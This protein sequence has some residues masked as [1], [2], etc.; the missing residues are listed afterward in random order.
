MDIRR[1]TGAYENFQERNRISNLC[2]TIQS[3]SR[4]LNIY[5]LYLN[6]ENWSVINFETHSVLRA[7][8]FKLGK[9]NNSAAASWSCIFWTFPYERV[10]PSLW[11][12]FF[13]TPWTVAHQASLSITNFWSLPKLVSVES[14]MPSSHLILCCPLFLLPSVFPSIRIFSNES[15]LHISWL[16]YWSFSFT[17]SP[18]IEYSGLISFSMDWLDFLAVQ[19]TLKSLLQQHSSKT[20]LLRHSAFFIVQLYIYTWLLEK[21]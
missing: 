18:S 6:K 21:P 7:A 17:V 1:H 3:I 16:K 9:A 15:V 4:W 10:A 11:V 19:G 20:S 5:V 12:Q 2:F 13:A 14:V 8:F